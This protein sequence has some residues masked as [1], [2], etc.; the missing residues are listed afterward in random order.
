MHQST[1]SIEAAPGAPSVLAE[2][3][4][5]EAPA[6]RW[7]L[8][9]ALVGLTVAAAAIRFV[10]LGVQS[11]HHDEVITI[12]RVIPGSFGHMLHEVKSSE[13][14]PPL[15]YMLAWGWAKEFGR[16]EWGIR[17]LSALLG[18]LTVPVGY[19]I[20]RQLSGRRV[21]LVLMAILA[22]CPMLIW[23]SQ[24]ARSYALLVLFGALS[25]LFFVRSL[26][27][28]RGRDLG[29]WAVASALALGSHYFAFFAVGIEAVWLAVALRDRWKALLPALGLVALVGASLLP[30]IAAQANP[31]HIGWIEESGLGSRFLQTG[32]SFLIGETGHVIAEPPRVHYAVLPAIAVGLGALALLAIG[33]ARERRGGVLGLAVG[34][35]VLALAGAAALV[36]KDYVIERNLLPALVPLAAVVALGLGAARARLAGVLVAV[37]LCAYWLAF[38]VYV[39]QT[40]NLQRPDY[41]GVA[42]VLGP[43]RVPRAIVSWRLAGDPL[44]WYLDDGAMRWFGGGEKVREVDLVGKRVVAEHVA[45]LPPSFRPAGVVRMDRLTIAR[46][47]S[48]RPVMLWKHQLDA[49]PTGYGAQTIVLDGPPASRLTLGEN[50]RTAPSHELAAARAE[51]G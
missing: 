51:A 34:L 14:N 23:Y 12:M 47:V 38:D 32:V 48:P 4:H 44:R 50:A 7:A 42:G 30:L 2:Q 40:P 5:E 6:R 45:N 17:S 36:G 10:P 27:T 13:S 29:L 31:N 43:P 24:E 16:S 8:A 26:D 19:A 35:G 22:F 1:A 18:T 41:R 25:F 9:A 46:Y 20:G 33:S 21:G 11:F 28:R 37:A 3:P 15:Y 49:L 39:T